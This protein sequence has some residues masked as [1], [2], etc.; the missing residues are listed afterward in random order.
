MVNDS[1]R[2]APSAAVLGGRGARRQVA[3]ALSHARAADAYSVGFSLQQGRLTG[4]TIYLTGN[5]AGGNGP[6]MNFHPAA[7]G[8][9]CDSAAPTGARHASAADANF[10]AA[11]KPQQQHVQ[12][13]QHE[14]QPRDRSGAN[15]A[16]APAVA[17]APAQGEPAARRRGC[18]A[19]RRRKAR[20]KTTHTTAPTV[21]QG[22]SKSEALGSSDS[23]PI[24]AACENENGNHGAQLSASN[25]PPAPS[26][27]QPSAPSTS[28]PSLLSASAPSFTPSFKV[29]FPIV[30]S[31]AKRP[32][33][34]LHPPQHHPLPPPQP[35][36]PFPV[37]IVSV[38]GKPCKPFKPLPFN[39]IKQP[40]L[41]V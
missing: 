23:V 31:P 33:S 17:D 4:F 8:A 28:L 21:A 37:S 41:A 6:R 27:P 20:R 29:P 15:A 34:P 5:F 18:R 2:P 7:Q 11:P 25:A 32:A 3:A 30:R 12:Q 40:K 14:H 13:Q 39:P 35:H 16:V 10:T 19:G 26:P 24:A 9:G 38:N 36:P 1:P 22:A